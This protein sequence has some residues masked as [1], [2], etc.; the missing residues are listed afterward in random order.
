M[1]IPPWT[2][3]LIVPGWIAVLAVIYLLF[4]ILSILMRDER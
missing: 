4:R 1:N 3:L 2:V